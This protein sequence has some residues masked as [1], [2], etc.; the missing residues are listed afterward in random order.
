MAQFA[1]FGFMLVHDEAYRKWSTTFAYFYEFVC[2]TI[3]SF[4]LSI[5][6]VGFL[7]VETFIDHLNNYLN[8]VVKRVKTTISMDNRIS[9]TNFENYLSYA[10]DIDRIAQFHSYIYG[11]VKSL[12]QLYG[13]QFLLF[14][15]YFLIET[16]VHLFFMYFVASKMGRMHR[17]HNNNRSSSGDF[18]NEFDIENHHRPRPYHQHEKEGPFV[19]PYVVLSVFSM[20]MDLYLLVN[21]AHRI[22]E[23]SRHS[24]FILWKFARERRGLDQFEIMVSVLK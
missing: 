24:R 2:H 19:N 8:D 1:T 20:F 11:L 18:D 17:T 15:L 3:L 5:L 9:A 4:E 14:V 13:V 23:K 7:V 16:V 10:T 21:G 22:Q 12:R 6:L